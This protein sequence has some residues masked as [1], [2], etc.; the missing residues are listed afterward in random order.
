MDADL[1]A[2]RVLADA[3]TLRRC[4]QCGCCSSACPL[5]GRDGFNVRRVLRH[6]ELGLATE[7]AA[8]L[9]PWQCATCVRCETACPNGVQIVDVVRAL[10]ALSPAERVPQG[11][12]P[13]VRACPGGIDVPGYLRLIARGDA[14]AAHQLILESVP[15]PGILGRVCTHPCE[16]AC[17]RGEVNEP[18]AI[19]ALKRYAADRAAEALAEPPAAPAAPS[20][21]RA[22]VIGAGP[23][24]LTAAHYLRKKGHAVTIFEAAEKPGGMMRHGIPRYRL[25]E[26]VLNREIARV[27][28]A[29]IELKT[30]VRLGRDLDLEQLKREGYEA[31]FLALGLQQGRRIDLEGAGLAGVSWGLDFLR[32]AA[33]GQQTAVAERVLV[34]GGGDVAVDAALTAL[35]LGASEVIMACLEKRE[36]MPAHPWEVEQALEEGVRLMTSFGPARVLGEGGRVSG[37]ELVRCLS[38]F[39]DEGRFSPRCGDERECVAAGE[40]ILAIGQASDLSFLAQGSGPTIAGGLV[41]ADPETCQ[42]GVPGLFAGGEIATGPGALID[43]IAQGKRAAAAIDRYLGGDGALGRVPERSAADGYDGGR[44]RGFADLKRAEL[45]VLPLAVRRPGFAE[46]SL[47][48]GAEAAE[49]EARRCLQCDLEQE[50]AGRARVRP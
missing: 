23:A 4:E 36:E 34:I 45:P 7:A 39:D 15:F 24:G 12:P 25:P 9:Q 43:A 28:E 48:L 20:G 17:R 6:V 32:A 47:C 10:R 1:A 26:D 46:V 21:R 49:G 30:G 2:A 13:C 50:A 41:A 27:L 22:A 42:T 29:G 18:I 44:E 19:C 3:K 40:V 14:R 37:I 38:V 16:S 35:R 5:T 11:P 31:V 33:A 8:T